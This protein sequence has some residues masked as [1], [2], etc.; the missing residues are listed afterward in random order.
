[1][2]TALFKNRR[3]VIATKHEKESV[4]APLLEEALGVSCFIIEG[5]DT[6]SWGTFSGE[7]ERKQDPIA[8]A[9]QK[10]L[11][12]ME[13][14]NCELGVASEGSFGAHPSLFFTSADDEFLIFI[15][16]KNNLHQVR[17]EAR[18][19]PERQTFQQG[20]RWNYQRRL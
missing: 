3:L 17:S 16:K 14:S 18:L 1:M 12:A 9:R 19:S 4:I 2:S 10:C 13:L 8:T 6:D 20:M 7:V 15:D 5:F 11:K